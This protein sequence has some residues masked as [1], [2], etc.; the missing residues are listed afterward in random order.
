MPNLKR[1][2]VGAYCQTKFQNMLVEVLYMGPSMFSQNR[3]D[4]EILDFN[5]FFLDN[6]KEFEN[7]HKKHGNNLILE[8]R[9][10]IYEN[11]N[12]K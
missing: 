9:W 11:M 5:Q 4:H 3:L 8:A 2:T 10:Y 7:F 1:E 12:E 6:Q